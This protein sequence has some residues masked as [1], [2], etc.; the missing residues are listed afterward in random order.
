MTGSPGSPG[1][2]AIGLREVTELLGNLIAI[3]SV[4]P[5]LVPSGPGEQAI[6][7]YVGRWLSTAGLEVAFDE[8][9]PGRPSVVAFARGSGGGRSL[10]LNAHLDTVGVE[11]IENPFSPR[12]EG[13]RM[14]G[15]GAYDMKAGLAAI[16]LAG[17]ELSRRRVA[18]DVIVSAVCDEEYAS[19]GCQSI[20]RNWSADACIVTEPTSLQVCVAHKGFAWARI[21]V[22]GR[23]AHGS[24]PDLGIDAIVG[25]TP[26]LEA[27]RELDDTLAHRPHPLLGPA[28]V[29]AS[30]IAGGQELSSYPAS[31]TLEL[32]RR[33]LPG[34]TIEALER[35]VAE[36]C[37]RGSSVRGQDVE[38]EMLLV[39]LPFAVDATEPIVRELTA[40]AGEALGHD[41]KHT[42]HSG[43]MDASFFAAAG[44]PT[45]IFGPSGHGA[46]AAVEYVE[47]DSVVQCAQIIVATVAGFCG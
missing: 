39:R 17:A 5:D 25:I 29:H 46:H 44:I 14:Y 4:N 19:I 31:C 27:I 20:L 30:M 23:A 13:G 8:A 26:V 41:P 32:E 42:G 40:Q 43:W 47:L 12:V 33:T 22:L 16:M 28:S 6:A 7:D 45:V 34:E 15:R 35:E 21:R 36:L 10:M 18:G 1:G 38:S 3:N 11:R 2:S 9:A 37:S 24:R